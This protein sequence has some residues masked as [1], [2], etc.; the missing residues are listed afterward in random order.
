MKYP[1]E[2]LDEIKTRLKVSSVVSKTVNLKKRGKEYV[3]LSPFKNE[4]TPSFTVNDEKEFYHC[5]ATSEHGN[6]FDFVMKTQNLKFGEAVRQLASF[7][8]MQPYI[9][10]K[11]DE[12]RE[13]KW[14][15]YSSIFNEY[16]NFYHD[17]L[18]KNEIYSNARDYLKDRSLNKEQVKKFKI[19]F[20]N[21]NPNFFEKL[22]KNY[23]TDDLLETGLFYLDE[24][25]KFMLKDLEGV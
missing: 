9:F 16:I 13:E 15:I 19:G 22:N 21:K 5:F 10:S 24:K 25:K 14:K 8:G 2:Y 6:I 11:Q 23:S 20:V 4:K 1:K 7:A 12:E 3:G 17:E 18:L